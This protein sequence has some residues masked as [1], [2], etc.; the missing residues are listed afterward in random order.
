[1]WK[2]RIYYFVMKCCEDFKNYCCK[3][4]KKFS[5]YV[6]YLW[7]NDARI[8]KIIVENFKKKLILL[9]YFVLWWNDVIIS[10]LIAENFE[11]IF[12]L[13]FQIF[14]A[15]KYSRI[16]K[17][18]NFQNLQQWFFEILTAFHH[19]ATEYIVLKLKFFI[20]SPDRGWALYFKG[21]LTSI[22][23]CYYALPL[24]WALS[25]TFLWVRANSETDPWSAFNTT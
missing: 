8:S 6:F 15:T 22:V 11:I 3:F 10:K 21:S 9:Y 1:M 14:I 24:D 4:E 12:V 13:N 17:N 16:Q 2:N 20:S 7:R 23:C 18:K 5:S 19:K 25:L